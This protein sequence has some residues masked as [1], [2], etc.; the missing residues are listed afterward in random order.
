MENKCQS[1]SK[2]NLLNSFATKT[3]FIFILG[4]LLLSNRACAEKDTLV[5]IKTD[6]GTL[7]LKLFKETPIHRTNFI[8]LASSGFYD[9][10]LFHRVIKNFMIQ[11]GDPVSKRATEVQ[12]LGNGEIGY[13]LPAEINPRFFHKKGALAAARL[14]DDI[15]PEKK[16]SGC[17]FYIVHGRSFTE[18]DLLSQE[19]RINM[20]GKQSLFMKMINL[21]ENAGLKNRF[22]AAQTAQNKDTLIALS[23]IAES[24]VEKEAA[25]LP[26]FKFSP[27]QIEAYKNLGGAPHLD[28]GYTVFGEVIEGLDVVDRIAEA[29]K[30]GERPSVDIR[31]FVTVEIVDIK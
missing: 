20:Q 19:S 28:G 24:M 25:S 10:L 26:Q 2:K 22:V 8:K 21:P 9:S 23:K 11:G 4:S 18:Q 6:Y 31:M 13:T 3:I 30:K 5:V 27:E 17:Q 15:N 14:G 12:P 29:E 16:S 1:S 7:K